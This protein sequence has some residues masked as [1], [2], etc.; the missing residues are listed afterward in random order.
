MN[1][2]DRPQKFQH[3]FTFTTDL[4]GKL[5]RFKLVAINELGSTTSDSYLEVLLTGL[6]SAPS[7][8]IIKI[9]STTD[10]IVVEMPKISTAAGSLI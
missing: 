3:T 5:I 7:T 1:V 6:P 2:E 4:T 10:E 9:L 8:S